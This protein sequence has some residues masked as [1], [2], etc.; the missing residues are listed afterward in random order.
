[1]KDIRVLNNRS[2]PM[3][4]KEI[5]SSIRQWA[6]LS[7]LRSRH[8]KLLNSYEKILKQNDYSNCPDCGMD[9]QDVPHMF[10]CMAHSNDLSP[11]NLWDKSVKTIWELSFFDPGI[12]D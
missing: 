12:L 10:N 7:Q 4:D 2:P 6:T 11:V 1:M 8:C 3:N 5:L 9:S